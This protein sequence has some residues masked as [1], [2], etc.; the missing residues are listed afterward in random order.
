[1]GDRAKI[2]AGL[3]ELNFGEIKYL[4]PDGNPIAK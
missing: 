4:D 2:E 3:K 1:V